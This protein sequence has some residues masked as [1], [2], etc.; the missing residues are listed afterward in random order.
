MPRVTVHMQEPGSRVGGAGSGAE[1]AAG[2]GSVSLLSRH[3]RMAGERTAGDKTVVCLLGP[4]A[5]L[6]IRMTPQTF[7]FRSLLEN[8]SS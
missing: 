7:Q 6:C 1:R 2:T 3:R 5:F 4:Q 8:L